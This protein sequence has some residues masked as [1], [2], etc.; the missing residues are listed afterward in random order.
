MLKTLKS[1]LGCFAKDK[2]Y[3]KYYDNDF[4]TAY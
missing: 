1:V 4:V 3:I 2:Q